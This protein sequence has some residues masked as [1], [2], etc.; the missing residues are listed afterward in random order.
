M[1]DESGVAQLTV[2]LR[3]RGQHQ[4]VLQLLN[5]QSGDLRQTVKL[6]GARLSTLHWQVTLS[7]KTIPWLAVVV[8]DADHDLRQEVFGSS[9]KPLQI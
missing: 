5:C 3:G 4:I 1:T 8:P 2:E 9:S 7:D 6:D